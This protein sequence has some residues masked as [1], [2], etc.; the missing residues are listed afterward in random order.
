MKSDLTCPVEIVSVQVKEQEGGSKGQIVCLIDFFNL[1]TKV[2]DSLQMNIICFDAKG[3]RLGGRLV[4]SA[5][6][7]EG[8]T[9]F[10]GS[11][12]PEHVDGAVRVEAAVEKVWYQ[13]GVLWRREERNVRDY[14]PNAL[15]QGRDLDR[16]KAVAGEDAAVG[17]E[18]SL[19][20]LRWMPSLL[21]S[22][23]SASTLTRSKTTRSQS[24]TQ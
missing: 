21:G 11:F 22:S 8:R 12:A 13:D 10:S 18:T 3:E 15:P 17:F 20:A 7:A 14:T 6:M 23:G 5:V 19:D 16:L 2:I 4:R 9:H 1:S 24:V